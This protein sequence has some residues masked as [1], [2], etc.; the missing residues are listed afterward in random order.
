MRRGSRQDRDDLVTAAEIAA[1]VYCQE[2]WRLQY[3][4]GLKPGNRAALDA[5]TRYHG[6]KAVGEPV[7]GVV[8]LERDRV[9]VVERQT[10]RTLHHVRWELIG[11]TPAS[12]QSGG[13][14]L[15]R[16]KPAPET[17]TTG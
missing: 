10:R 5:G 16:R 7:A 17:M 4:L 9:R 3:R 12:V 2:Q 1:F 14:N 8:I 15:V 13:P 11:C 6:R